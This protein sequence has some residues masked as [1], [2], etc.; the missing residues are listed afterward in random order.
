MR[1]LVLRVGHKQGFLWFGLCRGPARCKSP[2][3]ALGVPRSH[4][5]ELHFLCCH[6]EPRTHLTSCMCCKSHPCFFMPH[7]LP[8]P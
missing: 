7:H 3:R 5:E 1:S 6:V 8:N 4:L 2:L